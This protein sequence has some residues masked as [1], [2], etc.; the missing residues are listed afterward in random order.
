MAAP[1]EFRLALAPYGWGANSTA[2]T[3]RAATEATTAPEARRPAGTGNSRQPSGGRAGAASGL[4]IVRAGG[5]IIS[6]YGSATPLLGMAVAFVSAVA[7]IR[8]LLRVISLAGFGW[9]RLA[10]G[11]LTFGLLAAGRVTYDLPVEPEQLRDAK[12]AERTPPLSGG[13]PR[14]QGPLGRRQGQAGP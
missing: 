9:Y 2:V 6:T 12:A 1:G 8:W 7:A 5:D 13:K 10:A 11:L 4:E 3:V 14:G